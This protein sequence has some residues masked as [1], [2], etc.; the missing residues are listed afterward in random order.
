MPRK[1]WMPYH[2]LE[3]LLSEDGEA[4]PAQ[5]AALLVAL[6]MRGET[7]EELA[8]FAAAMRERVVHVDAPDGVV[9]TCG[10]GGDGSGTFELQREAKPAIGD[11]RK[12]MGRVHRQGGQHR[13]DPLLKHVGKQGEVWRVK[14]IRGRLGHSDVA[15]NLD[16]VDQYDARDAKAPADPALAARIA[17]VQQRVEVDEA[18]DVQRREA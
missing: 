1:T 8:G 7:V 6:R 11:K 16:A 2:V 13:K 4:T 5:L 17:A 18:L 14:D 10:T 12:R 3:R 9:D 15:G